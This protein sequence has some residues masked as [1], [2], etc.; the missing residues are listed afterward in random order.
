M[1]RGGF[2]EDIC[3]RLVGAGSPKGFDTQRNIFVNPPRHNE[4][5]PANQMSFRVPAIGL[6]APA[7]ALYAPAIGLYAPVG[8][9]PNY[10]RRNPPYCLRPT[11]SENF[12]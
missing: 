6:Y 2:V 11:F 8:L 10:K 4:R 3:R 9:K 7:I 5:M 12:C 1:C